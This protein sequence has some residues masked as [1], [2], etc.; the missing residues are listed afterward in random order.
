[1]TSKSR[2][3]SRKGPAI[4]SATLGQ[5]RAGGTP[6]VSRR[7]SRTEGPAISGP[8]ISGPDDLFIEAI[9]E[10]GG[11]VIIVEEER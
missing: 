2:N 11:T 9:L 10:A 4:G 3:K 7:G 1:M 5:E 6:Y 8:A